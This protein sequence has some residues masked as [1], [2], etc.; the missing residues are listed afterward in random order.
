MAYLLEARKHLY[1]RAGEAVMTGSSSRLMASA[2][3]ICFSAPFKSP[4]WRENI[5]FFD[6]FCQFPQWWFSACL[7]DNH[8]PPPSRTP[9]IPFHASPWG[10]DGNEH[11]AHLHVSAFLYYHLSR[12]IMC[13]VR[14]SQ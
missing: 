4:R 5:A 13:F 6:S 2:P 8:M 1:L 9:C 10:F 12:L 3:L 11:K 14:R 7:R